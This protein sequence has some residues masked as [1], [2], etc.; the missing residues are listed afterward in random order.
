MK[1]LYLKPNRE[2]DK[3]VSVKIGVEET[4][5]LDAAAAAAKFERMERIKNAMNA[6]ARQRRRDGSQLV[7]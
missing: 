1:H 2:S 4:P 6:S 7:G 3:P 5:V